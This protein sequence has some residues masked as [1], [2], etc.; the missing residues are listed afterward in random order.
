MNIPSLDVPRAD[1]SIEE[2]W[3]IPPVCAP[4]ALRRAIDGEPP[5]LETSVA[6]YYDDEVLTIVFRAEDDEEVVATYL[7]HD[8]PLWREDVVEVFL[9][10]NGLTPYFEIEVNPLGTTFDARIDSPDGIRAT[11]TTD[12]AWTCDGL[13]AA[14]LREGRAW[15]IVIRVPFASL[16]A[17]PRS[18][19]EWRGNLYRIDRSAAHGDDFSA[20]Q[21]TGK[22]PPD[23]HVASAFGAFRFT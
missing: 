8:E 6:A 21:P 10:P 4:V 2:P 18:G 16:G 17:A 19:D 14:L 9:A 11:M 3:A 13:F 12:R 22:T 7:G 15:H 20:W 5:R 23:F 1:F